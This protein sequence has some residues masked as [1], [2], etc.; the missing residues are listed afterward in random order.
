MWG[1]R[2]LQEKGQ[3][4]PRW[5]SHKLKGWIGKREDGENSGVINHSDNGVQGEV[6][7]ILISMSSS[8]TILAQVVSTPESFGL[9]TVFQI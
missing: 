4:G 2:I 8:T 5:R 3:K 1:M 9:V 6:R 7:S